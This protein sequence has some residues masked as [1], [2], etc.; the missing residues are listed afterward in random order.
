M[1]REP[2]LLP[3]LEPPVDGLARLRAKRESAERWAGLW[4][5]WRLAYGVALAGAA[6]ALL[7]LWLPIGQL[8]VTH[9]ADRL[10]GV[11]SQGDSLRTVDAGTFVQQ[12]P[13][14][15]PGVRLYWTEHLQ[16]GEPAG[17]E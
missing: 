4:P 15:Q 2:E 1:K 6:F 13:S 7:L 8:P 17:Q 16:S 14:Q 3:V 11:H 5:T 10:L 12:L 9:A